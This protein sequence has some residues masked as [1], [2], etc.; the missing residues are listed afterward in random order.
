MYEEKWRMVFFFFYGYDFGFDLEVL[1][2]DEDAKIVSRSQVN[3]DDEMNFI[4]VKQKH[5]L[6]LL[7]AFVLI[8]LPNQSL[9]NLLYHKKA[10]SHA[11]SSNFLHFVPLLPEKIE[12]GPRK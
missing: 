5:Y 8:P 10:T 12:A 6:I 1:C 9:T 4:G 7:Q 11:L 3:D 2:K